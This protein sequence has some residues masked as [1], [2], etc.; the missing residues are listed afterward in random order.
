MRILDI[1]NRVPYPAVTGAPLRTYNLLRRIAA[2]HE[3]FLAAFAENLEETEGA[4]FLEGMCRQVIAPAPGRAYSALRVCRAAAYAM[5]GMPAELALS[6]SR[7]MMARVRKLAREV[8][9]DAIIIE[10]GSMGD[11]LNCVPI[12]QRKRAAWML[13][14]IDY[15]KFERI[16][17]TE[18]SPLKS[19]RLRLHSAM[20]RRWMPRFAGRFGACITMSEADCSALLS[21]NRELK[22]KVCP[23]GVDTNLCRPLPDPIG[24]PALLFVG[25]MGYGPNID[26][27]MYFCSEILPIVR[28]SLPEVQV[29]IVGPNPP[30]NLRRLACLDVHV[31]GRVT[32]LTPYY[33][34]CTA[35]I[36]PLRAGG[37]T[38]LKILESMAFARP[39][40][41]TSVGCEGL[42]VL[43]EKHL[44]IANHPESF[45]R[46][47][48][49][50]LL[51][52][53]VRKRLVENARQ[54]VV[55][56]Y[57]WDAIA[58]DLLNV[59]G[60]MSN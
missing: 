11:Y 10:H 40:V 45:A 41:S 32:E 28:R 17:R 48:L 20:M 55:A 52:Q 29:W 54:L 58:E 9:F 14:D 42:E 47:T 15:K 23:N 34:R 21:A 39:V 19:L 6:Y 3:V 33:E 25:N 2:R 51:D 30:A 1:T 57:D 49:A 24:P 16:S 5:R 12:A 43:N 59:L 38:R 18:Q 44:L 31:T 37:G 53:S 22:V 56:R 46:N 4:R 50:I 7:E 35:S 8:D 36:V 26:G 27:A 60:A 13:H